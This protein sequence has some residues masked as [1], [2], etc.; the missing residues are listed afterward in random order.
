MNRRSRDVGSR[1]IGGAWVITL[2]AAALLALAPTAALASA[3]G[4][5]G[6]ALAPTAAGAKGA[7]L[8]PTAAVASIPSAPS[9]TGAPQPISSPPAVSASLVALAPTPPMGWN[10]WYKFGCQANEQLIEQTAQ[11][12]VSSGMAAAGYRYVN[13]DDCWMAASRDSSD[14]L[15]ADPQAFPDGIP[16]LASY[17]HGLGLKLGIYLDAGTQTCMLRPGSAAHFAQDA[18]TVASWGVDFIKVDYCYTNLI[19]AQPVYATMQQAILAARRPIVYSIS[20][21]GFDRPWFWGPGLAS[22]WRTTNDYTAYG[23]RS[24]DWWGAV[25]KILDINAGLYRFAQPGAWNDP[26]ILL[27]GTGLLT[28]PQERSQFSL[29]SMMAAPLL[30][31]GDVRT[32][33]QATAAILTNGE[34]IAVDQDPAGRQGVRIA[35]RSGHQVWIRRLLDGSIAVLFLNTASQPATITMSA[36]RAGVGR[37]QRYAVRDLWHHRSW[38]SSAP[39]IRARVAPD[40]VVMLRVGPA[41]SG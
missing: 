20:D 34:V 40:D 1:R 29:W 25:L 41:T 12:I 7:A 11:A 37:H 13:L 15:Q 5:K 28:V 27:I 18:A 36:A 35:D 23:A 8:A 4:A 17:V 22:L 2:L 30:A 26:D 6:A 32:M 33:S 24:G 31:G 9:S 38:S 19:P 21:D 39:T 10:P 3:P 14:A 16:A